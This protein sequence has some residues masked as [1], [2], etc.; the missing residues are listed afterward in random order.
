MCYLYVGCRRW[1]FLL[2]QLAKIKT[3]A[4]VMFG[5]DD[6]FTAA[7]AQQLLDGIKGSKAIVS[8]CP[9]SRRSVA[10]VREP[11]L[12]WGGQVRNSGISCE[13]IRSKV[14]RWCGGWWSSMSSM[15]HDVLSFEA[16][17]PPY[18]RFRRSNTGPLHFLERKRSGWTTL[19][20]ICLY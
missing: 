12:P 3:G 10:R 1:L 2:R 8:S 13:C 14:H 7:G 4:L 11:G 15:P 17:R 18:V 19:Y 16:R 9:F 5:T 6:T 20:N